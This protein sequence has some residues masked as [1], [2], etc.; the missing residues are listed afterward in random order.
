M[1]LSPNSLPSTAARRSRRPSV[2][3]KSRSTALGARRFQEFEAGRR[4]VEK[5]AHLDARALA[6]RR[7][8]HGGFHP[9]FDPDGP[10]VVAAALA[11]G[12]AEATDGADRGQRFAAEAEMIDAQEMV[13]GKLRGAM[14]LDRQRELVAVHADA[15]VADD[16]EALPALLQRHVDARRTG[17]DR[18]LDQ[19][20]QR[21]GRTL[22]HLAGGDAIDEGFRQK[23]NRHAAIV[24]LRAPSRQDIDAR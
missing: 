20:F 15:V 4:R 12:D 10:S 23:A 19:L 13:V 7:R 6:E 21:R 2:P 3:V 9:A 16:H 24:P 11:A 18:I 14:A 8:L 22:D 1:A 5:I 17:I